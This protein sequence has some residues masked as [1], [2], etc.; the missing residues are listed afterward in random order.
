MPRPRYSRAFFQLIVRARCVPGRGELAGRV[1]G[2]SSIAPRPERGCA[3]GVRARGARGRERACSGVCVASRGVHTLRGCGASAR[4]AK[5]GTLAL[6]QA[7]SC[8]RPGACPWEYAHGALAPVSWR[9]GK[10][11]TCSRPPVCAVRGAWVRN[12][13]QEGQGGVLSVLAMAA[14]ARALGLVVHED[15]NRGHTRG[16]EG[17]G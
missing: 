6:P 12:R 11:G 2:F 9:F 17:D 8:R 14:M 3:V 4:R 13:A 16:G 5:G 10:V 7:C 15:G 1:P